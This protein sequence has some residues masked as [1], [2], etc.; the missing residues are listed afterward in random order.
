LSAFFLSAL[1]HE[2]PPDIVT[3]PK[4]ANYTPGEPSSKL[5]IKN[6]G[7]DVD[8]ADLQ[9]VFG[10]YFASQSQMLQ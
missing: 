7:K 8:Q 2:F 5:Y 1:S 3:D 4:F 10:R 6:L 9:F